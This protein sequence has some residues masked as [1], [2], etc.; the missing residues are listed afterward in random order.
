MFEDTRTFRRPNH[1]PSQVGG[2]EAAQIHAMTA[3][4]LM[5]FT[6]QDLRTLAGR[7]GTYANG[8]AT[9]AAIVARIMEARS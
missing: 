9:K 1:R 3:E 7:V 8:G 4:E 5:A 2:I 6:G